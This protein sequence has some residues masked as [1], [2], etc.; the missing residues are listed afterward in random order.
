MNGLAQPAYVALG[1]AAG[2]LLR[3]S[4]GAAIQARWGGDFPL[5]T[6][7]VNLLGCLLIGAL[8]GGSSRLELSPAARLLLVSGLLGALT[9]FSTFA[10]EAIELARTRLD[11]AALYLAASL[12]AGLTGVLAGD[13]L[14][15][16][17]L[18]RP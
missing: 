17:A 3:W 6:W 5:G 15:A 13:A 11:L 12:I 7:S 9:T 18:P 2:A 8:V 1:G 16:A 14:A 4:L 10:L